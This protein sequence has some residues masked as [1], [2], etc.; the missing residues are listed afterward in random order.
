MALLAQYCCDH[1]QGESLED[2]LDSRVFLNTGITVSEP[3]ET[4]TQGI[5][6]YEKNF[7]EL[8]SKMKG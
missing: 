5:Q 6:V 3:C 2:W 1:G 8:I 7:R 4:D